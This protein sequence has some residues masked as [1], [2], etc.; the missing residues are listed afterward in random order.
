ME[1]VKTGDI[2]A[3]SLTNGK[4]AETADFGQMVLGSLTNPLVGPWLVLGVLGCLALLL[5]GAVKLPQRDDKGSR[6][7]LRFGQAEEPGA[8]SPSGA[9]GNGQASLLNADPD[10]EQIDA[11]VVPGG[12]LNREGLPTPW[13]QA[14][15]IRAKELYD[16]IITD[17]SRPAGRRRPFII[18]LSAGNPR[19]RGGKSEVSEA[20]AN[21]QYLVQRGVHARDVIEETMSK[22]TVGNAYF[23]R[24]L[25]ADVIGLRNL[26]VVT[27]RY[28]MPRTRAIF[29]KVFALGPFPPGLEGGYRLWFEESL[30]AG[31]PQELLSKRD[32]REAASLEQFIRI[33]SSWTSLNELHSF[34]Y[35]GSGAF[36]AG[37]ARGGKDMP[38]PSCGNRMPPD[39]SFCTRCGTR[40]P[41]PQAALT[42]SPAFTSRSDMHSSRSHQQP[43]ARTTYSYASGQGPPWDRGGA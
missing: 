11:V 30:D 4:T 5:L 13:V 17:P 40:R 2:T 29:E 21:A 41:E 22:D 25:H 34:I 27:S 24:T 9:F 32:D 38:C 36:V 18:T 20:M 35:R 7:I 26:I 15:L 1:S 33:S 23:L 31:I 43:T 14:R 28:H 19:A 16:T 3:K 8:V 10:D 12:G 42:W 6:S 39:G 37:R